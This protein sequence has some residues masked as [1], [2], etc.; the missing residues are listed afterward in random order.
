M[1]LCLCPECIGN[2]NEVFRNHEVSVKYP[3]RNRTDKGKFIGMIENNTKA[4][5]EIET[6]IG[7][8]RESYPVKWLEY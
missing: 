5:V 6:P 2:I 3:G 7:I 8:I 1:K 4:T